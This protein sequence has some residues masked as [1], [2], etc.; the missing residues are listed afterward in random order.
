MSGVDGKVVAITGAS[1]GIGQAAARLLA[2]RGARVVLAARRAE[3]LEELTR[4]IRDAGG[5]A[6]CLVADVARREDLRAVVDRARADFGRLDVLISNAGLMPVSPLDELRV[7]DWDRMVDVHVKGLLNG[8][9]AALP[10]FREQG[11][12]HFVNTAST[13]GLKVVP[14]MAVYAGTK[15]AVRM[16]SEG[17]RQEA[18]ERIRVTVVSPGFTATEFAAG[19]TNAEVREQLAATG[20]RIGMPPEAVARAMVYAIEQPPEVDVNEIVIRP[21]AQG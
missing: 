3:R 19:I 11:G 16:I 9:A 14:T 12:G 4:G 21:T 20:D 10:V 2:E 8:I 7:E 6:S 15:V 18:G 17:L 5:S 1:S 13:A